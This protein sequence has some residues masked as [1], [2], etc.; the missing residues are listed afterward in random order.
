MI[1]KI[2]DYRVKQIFERYI[3]GEPISTEEEEQEYWREVELQGCI[4]YGD[5]LQTA[6]EM[7][8]YND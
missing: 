5:V 4:D 3:N 2:T 8:E 7:G 6:I 1:S